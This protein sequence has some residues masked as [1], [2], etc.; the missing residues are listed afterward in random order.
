[1]F[2]N[3]VR[4]VF[5][6]AVFF[7]ATIVNAYSVEIRQIN[8]KTSDLIADQVSEILYASIPAEDN[9]LGNNIISIDPDTGEII[10]SVFV[11]SQPNKLAISSDNTTLYA[12]LDGSY[13]IRRI[14]LTTMTAGMQFNLGSE[15]FYGPFLAEDIEVL[16][17]S[18]DVIAVSLMNLGI[19]PRHGGVAVFDNGVKRPDTTRRHT[20]ANR[21]E[22]SDD[23]PTRVYGYNNETTEYG[24]RQLTVSDS[25]I[26]EEAV[27]RDF[28]SGFY[29]DIEF[30]QGYIYATSG[31]VLEPETPL[32]VGT[33]PLS[34][35]AIAVVAD[36]DNNVVYFLTSNSI[37]MFNLSNFTYIDSIPLVGIS[38]TVSSL[39][40]WGPGKLAFRTDGD[41]LYLIDINDNQ[42]D[43]DDDGIGDC[44]DN[45][46]EIT[47]P[48]QSDIDNDGL[49]DLCDPYPFDFDN[50][51]ACLVDVDQYQGMISS[52]QA[53]IVALQQELEE[54]RNQI[55]I[56]DDGDGVPNSYDLCPSTKGKGGLDENGCNN[57]QRKKKF[58]NKTH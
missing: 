18:N 22:F 32:V 52:L 17:G 26:Y 48:D 2:C 55:E 39:V 13:A 8:I 56:D 28:I 9:A 6:L 29:H 38:G 45:C 35:R 10:S 42:S 47:N 19:S 27:F 37:E 40:Q 36:S 3:Y 23:D 53:E 12:S 41:Q 44:I 34:N 50:L 25:G 54:L 4:Q 58:R 16:P 5:L 57:M 24:F 43:I 11:G 21:I 51:F 20:G 1:M 31:I 7:F 15:Y 46:P 49:G 30:H 14:D 33:Y